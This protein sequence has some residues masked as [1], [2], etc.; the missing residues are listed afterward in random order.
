[1]EII[2]EL[3]KHYVLKGIG[4]PEYYLWGNVEEIQDR[5]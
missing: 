3:Q 5:H 2:E 1:M 4:V